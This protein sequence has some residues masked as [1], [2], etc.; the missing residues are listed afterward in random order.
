MTSENI[1]PGLRE[2]EGAS[3]G[4]LTRLWVNNKRGSWEPV[5]ASWSEYR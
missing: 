3:G 1:L 4:Q 5:I 2:S